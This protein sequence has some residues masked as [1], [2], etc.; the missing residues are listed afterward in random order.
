MKAT[1]NP[2]V[3]IVDDNPENVRLLG[4]ILEKYGYKTAIALNGEDALAFLGK[5]KPEI[6]LLDIMMPGTDGFEVCTIVKKDPEY[7][8]IPIIFLT[9]K[10]ETDD[11]VRGFDAGAVDYVTKPFHPAELLARLR[12]HIEL[13][14]A[15]AEI[16]TLRGIVPVCAGCKSIRNEHDEWQPMEL[17]LKAHTD[18]DFSHGMCPI[19]VRKF[20][21]DYADTVLN[22]KDTTEFIDTPTRATRP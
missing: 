18:A 2:L 1:D 5:E 8:D 6:I 21:P 22:R 7:K 19:C 15:R 10:V 14:R 11:I 3:L 9:A 16:R 13:K 12:T 4:S 20:Y 17:Y